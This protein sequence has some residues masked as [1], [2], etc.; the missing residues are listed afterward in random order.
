MS[1][2]AYTESNADDH[3]GDYYLHCIAKVFKESFAFP[4]Y[5]KDS[6]V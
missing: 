4:P 6:Y 3:V 5:G 1:S 2:L